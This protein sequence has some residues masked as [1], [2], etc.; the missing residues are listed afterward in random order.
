MSNY[1]AIATVTAILQQMLQTGIANDVPGARVTTI[2]P[3]NAGS[4]VPD[5]GINIFLYQASPNPAWRN[6]DIRTRRP[7]DNLIKQAQAGLDLYYL[8]TFYGNEQE[9]EPQRLLGS[10]IQTIV[11]Q[12]IITP[13]IINQVIDSSSFPF[14][15]TSTLD[16]QVQLVQFIPLPMTTEELSRL[17]SIFFQLPYSLS[18]GF[19]ATAII[20]EGR[21]SGK[22]PLPV[23]LRQFYTVPDQPLIEQIKSLEGINQP[24]TVNSTLKITGKQLL[25][26]QTQIQI[27]EARIIPQEITEAKITLQLSAL[28]AQEFNSLKAGVQGLQVVHLIQNRLIANSSQRIESNVIPLILRPIIT[29]NPQTDNLEE[30]E[31]DLYSGM[32]EIQIDLRVGLK[33]RA[34]LLLNGISSDNLK[35][36]IFAA[37]RRNQNSHTLTFSLENVKQGDYLVRVQI[38]GAESMLNVDNDRYSG[39]ILHIP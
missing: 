21:K 5:T 13:D 14:L 3:D 35:S 27:G 12:P 34:F 16:Q 20:I 17:W 30:V 1:L 31:D 29:I 10:T 19:Q 32:I 2:R 37:R 26:N 28:S 8:L 36:Y 25:G 22:A 24:I 4:G 15:A 38:D 11:D 39:P 7:K 18:F 23:R 6:A 33:Q 9:L